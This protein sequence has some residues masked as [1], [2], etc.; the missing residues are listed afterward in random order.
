MISGDSNKE[1]RKVDVVF[2]LNLELKIAKKL[3]KSYF[4][5]TFKHFPLFETKKRLKRED[6]SFIYSR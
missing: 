1:E 3:K 2:V 6:F 4:T 5:G